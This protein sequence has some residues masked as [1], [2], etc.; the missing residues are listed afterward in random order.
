MTDEA[1]EA[2]TPEL[3]PTEQALSMLDALPEQTE[4]EGGAPEAESDPEG[5]APEE[6]NPPSEDPSEDKTEEEAKPDP[7]EQRR[8]RIIAELAAKETQLLEAKATLDAQERRLQQ[9]TQEVQRWE[10][11]IAKAKSD[12]LGFLADAGIDV[13]Q[14]TRQILNGETPE[15]T[16]GPSP[17]VKALQ[18]ELAQLKKAQEEQVSQFRQRQIEA[19]VTAEKER[20][21]T[22]VSEND[23]T[24][25]LLSALDTE[26]IQGGMFEICR[27]HWQKTHTQLDPSRAARILED[28]LSSYYQK[29]AKAASKQ[30]AASQSDQAAPPPPSD[31]GSRTLSKAHGSRT[32]QDPSTLSDEERRALAL[33]LLD[34]V[35]D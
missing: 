14:L 21:S 24:Y 19:A 11:I 34:G 32:A 20:L 9:R 27:E 16:Q 1:N 8:S 17:E 3:S 7:A 26:E 25:P 28:K 22:F 23:T 12:P 29:L 33:E 15:Q 30:K 31:T 2:T 10:G 4:D 35:P 6:E 5:V 18:D 13:N